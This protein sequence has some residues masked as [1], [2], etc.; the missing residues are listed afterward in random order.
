MERRAWWGLMLAAGIL[1]ASGLVS[2]QEPA[3]TAEIDALRKQVVGSMRLTGTLAVGPA[4]AVT[5]YAIDHSEKV[6][7]EVLR[8]VARYVPRWRVVKSG[9]EGNK[10]F[11]V[12]VMA[13]PRGDGNFA[14][15][16]VGASITQKQS[17]EEDVVARGRLKIPDYP[18]SLARIGVSGTVYVV[19][20]VGRDGGVQ[21]LVIEQVN[22][23]FVGSSAEVARARADF[24][25]H[26][27]A[28]ARQWKFR[29]PKTAHYADQPYLMVRVPVDYKIKGLAAAYA[30]WEYY[31]PGPRRSAPWVRE[32]GMALGAG[33]A[34]VP[35]VLGMGPR[36]ETALEPP[37]S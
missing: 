29:V 8:H 24:A 35:Q 1:I 37:A 10:R 34:G 31:V 28:A 22:L 21:D 16:L 3:G 18:R 20:K 25:G 4:G 9:A 23:N 12:R 6:P 36:I 32:D 7:P 5:G 19:V 17:P 2:A 33:E 30:E 15:S 26:S 27:A 14:L 11:A 13:T